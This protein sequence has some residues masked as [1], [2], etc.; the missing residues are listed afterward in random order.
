VTQNGKNRADKNYGDATR[1]LEQVA[2]STGV[3]TWKY[4]TDLWAMSTPRI[5]S[6]LSFQKWR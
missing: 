4:K 2:M 3:Q 5:A 6:L 1:R